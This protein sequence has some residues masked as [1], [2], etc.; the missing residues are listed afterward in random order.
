MEQKDFKQA[1]EL[2]KQVSPKR[3]FKQSYD[4]VI[5]LQDMDLKK[6]DQQVDAF[7]NLP[8]GRGRPVK[9]GAF[10]GPEM[11]EAAKKTCDSVVTADEF[12]KYATDTNLIK[13]LAN[14]N[15]FFIAQV[16]VMP[17]LA[18]TF[19]KVL[20]VR[21]KMPNPKAGMVVPQGANLKPVIDKLKNV[22]RMTAKTQ[23][24]TKCTVGNETMP[25][26]QVAEN[27]WAAYTQFKKALPQEENNV[28]NVILKLTMGPPIKVGQPLDAQKKRIEE[29][30][31]QTAPKE[32]KAA[33]AA[34][35]STDTEE[36][37][38]KKPKKAK[39]EKKAE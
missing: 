14:A 21:G 26:E 35:K 11:A 36:K 29:K 4:L 8:H 2:L 22:V 16:T 15:D 38:E 27:A 6:T 3:E 32:K 12:P 37:A 18:K 31:A 30:I 34:T 24:S 33:N 5:N 28:K 13:K 1:I 17:G 7:V 39:K 9:I 10:V 23:L 20:G 25:E 19:G